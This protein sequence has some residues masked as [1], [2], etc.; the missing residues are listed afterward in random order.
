MEFLDEIVARI[1][2]DAFPRMPDEIPAPP[3]CF[4]L[5]WNHRRVQFHS[6]NT[7][8]NGKSDRNL[9]PS[10]MKRSILSS[11]CFI[12]SKSLLLRLRSHESQH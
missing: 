2:D 7:S 10:C 1:D 5:S 11:A 12:L 9:D 6:L 3:V 4:F 8:R